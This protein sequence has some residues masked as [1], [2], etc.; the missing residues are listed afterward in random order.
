MDGK[1]C[2]EEVS[3][4]IIDISRQ[5]IDGKMVE[6][7]SN[8]IDTEAINKWEMFSTWLKDNGVIFMTDSEAKK[9][10]SETAE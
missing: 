8:I 10:Y 1:D 9:V 2:F 4:K 5:I 6:E 7:S 3:G